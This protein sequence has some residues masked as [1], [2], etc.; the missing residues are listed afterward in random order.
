MFRA[1]T[2]ASLRASLVVL[3]LIGSVA[4]AAL[5]VEPSRD[6][7]FL[8][9]LR[10]RGLFELAE[11]YCRDR[12]AQAELSDPRAGDAHDPMGTQPG[13][14]GRR[15]A[16]RRAR[17]GLA[18]GPRGRRRLPP[19]IPAEPAAALGRPA[20]RLGPR[21]PR[22][23]GARGVRGRR[24]GTAVAGRSRRGTPRGGPPVG[25]TDRR[26]RRRTPRGDHVRGRRRRGLRR[27]GSPPTSWR[28]SGRTSG[29]NSPGRDATRG[30]ALRPTAPIG[31]TR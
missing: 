11:T 13:R 4:S 2:K 21:C 6:E 7:R 23:T 14:S 22:R 3:G 10:D 25:A 5:G 31:P 16:A 29:F 28:R 26:G 8:D 27:T 19:E 20:R 1:T 24:R 17:D 18:A 30:S 15:A 9:G 12:L